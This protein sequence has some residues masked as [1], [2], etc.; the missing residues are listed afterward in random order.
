MDALQN[1]EEVLRNEHQG[2]AVIWTT[3]KIDLGFRFARWR[4]RWA[5]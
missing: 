2:I 1:R 5:R 3:A 4:K